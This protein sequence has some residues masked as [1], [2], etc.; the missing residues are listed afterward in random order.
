[1]R[2]LSGASGPAAVA[3]EWRGARPRYGRRAVGLARG[4]RGWDL[5][6]NNWAGGGARGQQ[7]H[8]GRGRRERAGP[9]GLVEGPRE[10]AVR[11]PVT[12]GGFP[13]PPAQALCLSLGA[14]VMPAPESRSVFEA[15]QDP[16]LLHGLTL[17]VGAA[18]DASE[19]AAGSRGAWGGAGAE[20]VSPGPRRGSSVPSAARVAGPRLG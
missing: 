5:G 12:R 1:M 3:R 20:C 7:P 9:V 18:A 6:G 11:R 13:P 14:G 2:Q 16:V 8:G 17:V 4:Q 19:P 10:A 15:A